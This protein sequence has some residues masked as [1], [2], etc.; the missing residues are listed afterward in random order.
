MLEAPAD[1]AATDHVDYTGGHRAGV[2]DQLLVV[3]GSPVPREWHHRESLPEPRSINGL[4]ADENVVELDLHGM[5]RACRCVGGVCRIGGDPRWI[6]DRAFAM[7]IIDCIV[8][9]DSRWCRVHL[10]VQYAKG[11]HPLVS[12]WA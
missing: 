10:G 12:A 2:G 3:A 7:H 11:I 1:H 8:A 9:S 5:K 4:H 6:P